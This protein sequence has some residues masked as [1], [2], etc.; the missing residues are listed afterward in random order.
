MTRDQGSK[1]K[2]W[3]KKWWAITLGVILVVGILANLGDSEGTA[4]D[5]GGTTTTIADV[6]TTTEAP[7]TT[8]VARTTTTVARTTTTVAPTNTTTTAQFTRSEQNAIAKAR[9]YLDYTSFSRSGLIEQLEYEGFSNAEST[10]AADYLNVDWNEQAWKKAEEYLAYTSF[11]RSGL[12]GQLEYE[13]FTTEQ[14]TYGVD[15]TGL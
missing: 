10:L 11:S 8:T 4:V 14:A 5:A 3:Y 2:P 7:T 12:I 13:G 6:V 1:S 15:K 9:D